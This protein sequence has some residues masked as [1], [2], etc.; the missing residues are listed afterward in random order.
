MTWREGSTSS[1]PSAEMLCH[2]AEG[3]DKRM[4]GITQKK[5]ECDVTELRERGGGVTGTYKDTLKCTR[6]MLHQWQFTRGTN[7][8]I[9]PQTVM[10]RESEEHPAEQ[11]GRKREQPQSH[12]WR[13]TS[14]WD[15]ITPSNNRR[16]ISSSE[17]NVTVTND[18]LLLVLAVHGI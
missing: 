6:A 2:S 4:W 17:R 16:F 9:K 7:R 11:R 18:L 14:Y 13:I 12:W 5:W 8:L 3:L 15:K 10:S 1:L